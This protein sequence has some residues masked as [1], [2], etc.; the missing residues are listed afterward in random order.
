MFPGELIPLTVPE[1]RRLLCAVA[2]ARQ[3]YATIQWSQGPC[4]QCHYRRRFLGLHARSMGTAGPAR[5]SPTRDVFTL[6]ARTIVPAG[7]R[8]DGA[9]RVYRLSSSTTTGRVDVATGPGLRAVE[10]R[11]ARLV[12]LGI[13]SPATSVGSR[14]N[15]SCIWRPRWPIS[16]WWRAKSG[17]WAVPMAAQQ[18]TA[19][20]AMLSALWSPMRRPISAPSGSDNYGP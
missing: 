16:P 11:L 5:P 14:R 3:S 19:S 1:V 12:Q 8:T 4:M 6:T 7:K 18:A 17:C 13:R 2:A 9:G 20:S 10:H 15:S